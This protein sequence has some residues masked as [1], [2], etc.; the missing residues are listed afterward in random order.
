MMVK[1][2]VELQQRVENGCELLYY[3]PGI[4]EHV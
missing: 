4:S 1:D 2:A 3:M